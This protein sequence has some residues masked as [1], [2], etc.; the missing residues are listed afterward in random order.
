MMKIGQI[1]EI[2]NAWRDYEIN[3]E[4][5]I[6]ENPKYTKVAFWKNENELTQYENLS[7]R[8]GFDL[9]MYICK[10]KVLQELINKYPGTIKSRAGIIDNQAELFIPEV[11]FLN[12]LINF[13]GKE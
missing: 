2:Q 13:L 5:F 12:S 8:D 3:F 1:K 4:L 6:Q 10:Q 11:G 9:H 7:P